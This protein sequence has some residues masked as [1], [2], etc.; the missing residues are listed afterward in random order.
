M[1]ALTDL[2]TR[3]SSKEDLENPTKVK[4]NQKK[5]RKEGSKKKI[6]PSKAGRTQEG[7]GKVTEDGDQLM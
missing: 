2:V 5:R 6:G 3:K 7:E 1:Q 4:T